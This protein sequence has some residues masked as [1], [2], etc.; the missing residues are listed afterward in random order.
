[1]RQ[2]LTRTSQVMVDLV[3]L[4]AAYFLAFVLRFEG[5]PELWM[6]KRFV[7]NWPYVVALQYLGLMAFGV[8]RFAW[9]YVGLREASRI[10]L[11]VGLSA[12]MLFVLRF[13]STKLQPTYSFAQYSHTP[14]GVILLDF[15]LAVLGVAGVRVLRRMHAERTGALRRAARAVVSE[16][17]TLLIGAGQAGVSVAREIGKHPELGIRPVGFLDDDP[18]KIGTEIQ[19]ISVLGPTANVAE[20][21]RRTG[22]AQ[23][24]ITIA[25]ASGKDIRR[26]RQ[27]CADAGLA[28]KIVPAMFD[29]LDG[30]VSLSRIRDVS[31]DDLLGREPVRLETD[32]IERFIRGKRVLVTGAG[33]SIGSELCRQVARF[34]PEALILVERAEYHL[35]LIHQELSSTF[36][37]L[38]TVPCIADIC[39]AKRIEAVFDDQEPHVVF[40]AAAHKHVPMMEWNSGEAV[41]NNVFGTKE[42]ADAADR[43]AVEAFV[44]IST[45]KAVNPSSV[46]GATKRVAEM[47]VQAL[48]QRSRTKYVAVRFG[49]VLG[50]TGS[51]IP[52][53]KAQIAKGGPVTVTH[54]DMQRYFMTIPEASQLVMQAA[55]MGSGGEIFVLDMGEPV[56]IVDLA[57]DLIRL[58]GFEVDEEIK[59]EFA[60]V[61]PGEKLFEELGFD[62][63]KMRR[64]RHA[65][66][67]EGTMAPCSWERITADLTQLATVTGQGKTTVQV[68]EVLRRAVPEML[69]SGQPATSPRAPERLAPGSARRVDDAPSGS[70]ALDT[71]V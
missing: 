2:I 48:S 5:W 6:L 59:I 31:I 16:Q 44:L 11:A 13:V 46:M 57:R 58:S 20:S 24:L 39:D 33:G 56:R 70:A 41:K 71:L 61:R 47:Y 23:A 4:A 3:V 26:I 32:L 62:A 21:A 53:F 7:L 36:P 8:H 69:P 35:F 34:S 9:S 38:V 25:H 17:P 43:H 12:A 45:D 19:G 29:I 40:H 65:K 52:T 51:V 18:A 15:A 54:P 66:I 49:N 1:M 64:T 22:A 28:V 42:V 67:F 30:T 68:R 60:G 50:S 63:E 37:D 27:L 14:G 55:A 10:V